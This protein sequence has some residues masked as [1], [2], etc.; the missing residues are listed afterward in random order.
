MG[1]RSWL[2]YP[3]NKP[4]DHGYYMTVHQVEDGLFYKAIYWDGTQW[5][6]WRRN[7]TDLHIHRYLEYTRENFYTECIRNFTERSDD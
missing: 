2:S 4:T 1:E 6:K 7:Q 3:E 5:C